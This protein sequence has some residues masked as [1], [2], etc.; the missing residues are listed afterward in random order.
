MGFFGFSR[1]DIARQLND[2]AKKDLIPDYPTGPTNVDGLSEFTSGKQSAKDPELYLFY[3]DFDIPPAVQVEDAYG[4]RRWQAGQLDVPQ[5]I[6]KPR[7]RPDPAGQPNADYAKNGQP[8]DVS[9]IFSVEDSGSNSAYGTATA[10]VYNPWNK[11]IV[12]KELNIAVL[13]G[14]VL[15]A[16]VRSPTRRIRFRLKTN[17]DDKG[18][19]EARVLDEWDTSYINDPIYGDTQICNGACITVTDPRKLFAHAVGS[20]SLDSLIHSRNQNTNDMLHAGGSV[21]YAIET[22]KI[23]DCGPYTFPCGQVEPTDPFDCDSECPT[24]LNLKICYPRFEVEQCTQTVNKMRVLI[25]KK[26]QFPKGVNGG[27]TVNLK[28]SPDFAFASQWPYVDI[29]D[30]LTVEEEDGVDVYRLACQNPHRFTAYTGWAVI[31]RVDIPSRVQNAANRCVPYAP[32]GSREKEWHIVDVEKPI[33]RYIC[34]TYSISGEGSQTEESWSYAGNFFEGENPVEYFLDPDDPDASIDKHIETVPCLFVDCLKDGSSGVAFWDYK[35]QKYY[36]FSTDSALY[37]RAKNYAVVGEDNAEPTPGGLI[38]YGAE[39]TLQY[40]V[41]QFI[42]AFGNNDPGCPIQISVLNA[43]P[44]LVPVQVV[45]GVTRPYVCKVDGVVDPTI[46]DEEACVLAEGIWELSEELCFDYKSVY[47]CKEEEEVQECINICCEEVPVPPEPFCFYCDECQPENA[48]VEFFNFV[49]RWV[50]VDDGQGNVFDG[51]IDNASVVF[52]QS[53]QG[54]CCARLE[55][56]LQSD[57]P[58]IADTPVSAEV[59][60][61]AAGQDCPNSTK[62]VSFSWSQ[63]TYAGVTLPTVMC[64]GTLQGCVGDYGLTG[65]AGLVPNVPNPTTGFWDEGSIS[66]RGC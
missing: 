18:Y 22:Y 23:D 37:G 3:S 8:V 48:N 38:Q 17:F 45:N 65:G 11:P 52:T 55:V 15:F 43:N 57:N 40:K 12:A 33:A 14:G 46:E 6:Y 10:F 62:Q 50:G 13:I 54:D 31:E 20:D 66:I 1:E 35:D 24:L 9:R 29:P 47:V 64:G 32:M 36:V 59:C 34:V 60:I 21:G 4:D 26:P 19:A 51:G 27:E 44:N 61:E 7:L 58:A 56:T 30:N 16:L 25:D 63:N 2:L 41:S 53:L 42:K 49:L 28:V 5:K 39:C